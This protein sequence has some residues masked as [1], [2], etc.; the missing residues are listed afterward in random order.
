MKVSIED[1]LKRKAHE[2][3]GALKKT[4]GQIADN[5]RVEAK[6]QDEEV[7]GKLQSKIGQVKKVFE[8]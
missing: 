5:P 1:E 3:R 4:A 8:K 7:A 6:G 2:V